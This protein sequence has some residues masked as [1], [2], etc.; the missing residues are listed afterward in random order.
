MCASDARGSASTVRLRTPRVGFDVRLRTPVGMSTSSTP[1]RACGASTNPTPTRA[2]RAA[3]ETAKHCA[4]QVSLQ[5][6]GGRKPHAQAV[7]GRRNHARRGDARTFASVPSE[8][9]PTLRTRVL[10]TGNID[11]R[12]ARSHRALADPLVPPA[13]G[14]RSSR[15][16]GRPGGEAD[17]R[18]ARLGSRPSQAAARAS[19]CAATHSP[20]R[21]GGSP[22]A[23]VPMSDRQ[24][25]RRLE[26]R[27]STGWRDV[28]PARSARLE[29]DN[30]QLAARDRL[31]VVVAAVELDELRPELGDLVRGRGAR[32]DGV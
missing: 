19:C 26:P 12:A 20:R 8:A 5:P 17:R 3:R 4:V 6:R 13:R 31:V 23:G 21:P 27:P 10:F 18:G 22:A 11:A 28:L 30:G 24:R 15:L 32:G 14:R 9:P 25:R 16:G 29:N 7:S 2:R 1:P